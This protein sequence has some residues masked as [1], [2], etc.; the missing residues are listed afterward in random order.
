M[1][2]RSDRRRIALRVFAA[3]LAGGYALLAAVGDGLHGLACLGGDACCGAVEDDGCFFC[4]HEADSCCVAGRGCIAG[5]ERAGCPQD[6]PAP[7]PHDSNCD[8]CRLL[9]QLKLATATIEVPALVI[10]APA[11]TRPESDPKAPSL[12][13]PATTAR[14]PPIA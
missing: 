2:A 5:G 11:P 10:W 8:V 6:G 1:P 7:K 4:H 14:G 12:S 13:L 9:A 3:V